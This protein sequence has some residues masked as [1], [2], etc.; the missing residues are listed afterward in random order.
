ML[1]VSIVDQ[2]L[3]GQNVRRLDLLW[4]CKKDGSA[5]KLSTHLKS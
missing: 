2:E 3:T 1:V 4:M 5:N